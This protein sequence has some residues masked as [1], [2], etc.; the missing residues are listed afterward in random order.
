MTVLAWEVIESPLSVSLSV[1]ESV[2]RRYCIE[3][4]A[5]IDDF[6]RTGSPRHMLHCVLETLGISKNTVLPSGTLFQIVDF[7]NLA[8]ACRQLGECDKQWSIVYVTTW[9]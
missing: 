4:A 7:E 5:R 2:T 6:L 1:S 8:T 9:Q 3:T